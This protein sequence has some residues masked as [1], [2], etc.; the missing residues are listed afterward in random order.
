MSWFRTD[1]VRRGKLDGMGSERCLLGNDPVQIPRNFVNCNLLVQI[2][3]NL[4]NHHPP[5]RMASIGSNNSASLEGGVCVHCNFRKV[6]LK[7]KLPPQ[8]GNWRLCF[9]SY[10]LTPLFVHTSTSLIPHETFSCS[11]VSGQRWSSWSVHMACVHTW[12]RWHG[13]SMALTGF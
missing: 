4:V 12:A 11:W 9:L 13:G 10:N 1:G 7:Y 8:K 6:W 2:L 3:L 5:H